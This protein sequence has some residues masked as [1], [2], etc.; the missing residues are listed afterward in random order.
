MK[1]YT[2]SNGYVALLTVIILSAVVTVI[3]TSL[4]LLGLGHSRT[5]LSEVQSAS[6]KVAA[7]S[8]AEEAL[9][10]VRLVASYTGN[11]N[12][13]LL[14]STCMYSVTANATSSVT[15]TGVSGNTTRRVI[16]DIQSRTPSIVMT[17]WQEG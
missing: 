12:L 7:D 10:Q 16:I 6:A 1:K 9:K 14:N 8:C 5:A 13:T 2:R 3:A 4:V 11:G 17:K 15:A